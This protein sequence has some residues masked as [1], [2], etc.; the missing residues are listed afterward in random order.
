MK[1]IIEEP[2]KKSDELVIVSGYASSSFLREVS[3][4]IPN[5][6]IKLILG[7]SPQGISERNFNGFREISENRENVDVFFQICE[8]AT[9]IKI[10][11]W[12]LRGRPRYSYLGSA[13]FSFAGFHK[14]REILATSDRDF[15]ELIN[16]IFNDCLHCL[17][18]TIEKY[19]KVYKDEKYNKLL[20][21][22]EEMEEYVTEEEKK[23]RSIT[24]KKNDDKFLPKKMIIK[25][26]HRSNLNGVNVNL[27]LPT[28]SSWDR[29]GLNVWTRNNKTKKDSYI[30]LD[31]KISE[32]NKILPKDKMFVLETEDGMDFLV[33]RKGEYGRELVM[34]NEDTN[35]YD[36]FSKK[37][38]LDTCRL[39]S[40][41]DLEAYGRTSIKITKIGNNRFKLYF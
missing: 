36:Y 33:G 29:R 5:H 4:I 8:P 40:Y 21:I 2:S 32:F 20:E 37:I 35:F 23:P 27:V 13:N 30:D 18:S 17:D 1:K 9:H 11:Q 7:M 6:K 41:A 25:N 12:Y 19:I 10:Y 28:D 22:K 16:S 31:K 39:I 14:Q 3:N 38:E 24:Y 34:V 15:D 26:T